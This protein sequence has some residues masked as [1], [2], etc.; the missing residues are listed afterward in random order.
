[1][2]AYEE[3]F[4]LGCDYAELDRQDHASFATGEAE[5]RQDAREAREASDTWRAFSLGK[6]RGYREST[7]SLEHGRW[8]L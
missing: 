2:S 5:L 4:S 6:V 1:M 3:G 7:R 8:G